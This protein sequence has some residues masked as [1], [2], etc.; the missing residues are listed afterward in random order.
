MAMLRHVVARRAGGS[1]SGISL[2][3]FGAA[4]VALLA[5]SDP[6]GAVSEFGTRDEAVAMVHRVQ[7]M[8][9]KL[10]L[11]ATTQA[12]RRKA[13][14][15]IDRDLY[16]YIIDFNGLVVA[17][18]AIPTMT[19]GTNLI[20][21]RDQNGKYVMRAELEI[22]KGPQQRGWVD[23][24]WL[25]PATQ[26]IDDK[27]AYLERLGTESMCV[28]VGIYRNE[29][30]N[31]NTVAII[32][33]SPSADDTYLQVANDLA[34]ILNDSDRLRI[35]PIVG[36]GGHQNIRDVRYLKGVD[37][38]LTQ[39]SVLNSF[40]NS[41]QTLGK[42]DDKIVYIGKL[43]N[44]EVHLIA[45]S[46]ITSIE[47]LNGRKVN[48]DEERSGTTQ[49][50]RDVFKRLGIKVEEVN[51]TQG[52]AFE[53]LKSGE[54]V[55]TAYVAGKA[56]KLISNLK[57]ERGM[58]FLQVPYSSEIAAEYLPTD[59]T[60][61]DYPDLIPAGQTIQTIADEVIL[62]GYNWPKNTDRYRRVQR[63]V[64]AFFPKIE[65]F[66]KAPNHPKWREVNLAVTVKGWKR[67]EPADEWLAAHRNPEVA[68]NVQ[69]TNLQ[70]SA[71]SQ[72]GTSAVRGLLPNPSSADAQL[73]QE[74]LKWKQ[75]QPNR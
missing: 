50:M 40:R 6:V 18:G 65:E 10:G 73:Y 57:F 13:P 9:K 23:F 43:F 31:E 70:S 64:E 53:K 11:E 2:G 55:A 39:L 15:T 49:T 26:S 47:Q 48:I 75:S 59:L 44:E 5:S 19:P 51:V 3:L 25:N 41:N 74:F 36:I 52:Q 66:W 22:C 67:F 62:I 72:G 54:I 37:I 61:D 68:A 32:S 4:A 8:Y 60:H 17:N 38:G 28:G 24:R 29:Q 58:H 42:Y 27:S 69:Q 16:A 21:F 30:I 1:I 63:F 34:S 46:E 7:D 20:N 71:P 14:G 56:A 12:I 45:R 35:L 33:G